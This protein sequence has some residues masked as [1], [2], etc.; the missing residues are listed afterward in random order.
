[1]F[2]RVTDW[3]FRIF[4]L[5]VAIPMFIVIGSVMWFV[6]FAVVIN[7]VS[8]FFGGE[9]LIHLPAFRS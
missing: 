3:F 5:F 7:L 2:D 4:V 1:M 8:M 9:P 6:I